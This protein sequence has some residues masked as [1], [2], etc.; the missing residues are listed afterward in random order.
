MA[1]RVRVQYGFFCEMTRQEVSG[2]ITAIGLWGNQ[3]RIQT[4]G[5]M[6]IPNLAFHAY[7]WNPDEEHL[8]A[9][10]TFKIPGLTQNPEFDLPLLPNIGMTGHN[11]VLALAGIPVPAPGEITLTL[12]IKCDPPIR[13]EYKLEIQFFPP[14]TVS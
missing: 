6:I 14:P 12:E 3:I 13:E 4:L 8:A 9:K 5:P 11:V 10:A 2:Q 7:V 1:S